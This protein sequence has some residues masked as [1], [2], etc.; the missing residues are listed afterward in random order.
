M[1]FDTLE[2]DDLVSRVHADDY[3]TVDAAIHGVIPHAI[4]LYLRGSVPFEGARMRVE[5][6]MR[7]ARTA[8]GSE[9]LVRHVQ[10]TIVDPWIRDTERMEQALIAHEARVRALLDG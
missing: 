7:T 6:A 5:D 1:F 2:Y 9:A 10:T 8:R 3:P 4:E